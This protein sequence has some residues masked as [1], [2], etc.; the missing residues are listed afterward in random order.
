[1]ADAKKITQEE[2]DAIRQAVTNL[3]TGK[4]RLGDLEYQKSFL[5]AQIQQLEESLRSEQQ[6][7]EAKYGSIS[8]NLDNGEYTEE[9]APAEE[10]LEPETV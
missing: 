8:I 4:T 7:L 3:S 6:S 1:M 2:L 5:I 10:V 9:E